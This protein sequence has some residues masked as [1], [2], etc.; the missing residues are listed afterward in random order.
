M[1]KFTYNESNNYNII[2][3]HK[4]VWNPLADFLILKYLMAR[5]I[6]RGW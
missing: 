4:F 2:S 5:K 3:L 1:I 6:E